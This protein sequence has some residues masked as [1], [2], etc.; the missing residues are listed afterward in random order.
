MRHDDDRGA[1]VGDLRRVAGGD[2]AFLVERGTQ[3]AEALGGR[4]GANALVGVD[5]DRVALALRDLDVDDLVG[6]LAVLDGGGG[7]LVRVGGE[8]VLRFAADRCRRRS[9]SVPRPIAQWSN[10]QVRPSYIIES[11]SVP[12]PMR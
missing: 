4:A 3:A 1:A 9:F 2:R 12:S 11:T 5:D 8:R 6:E 10:A 7:A